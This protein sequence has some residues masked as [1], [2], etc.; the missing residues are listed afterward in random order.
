M[1]LSKLKFV[2]LTSLALGLAG[3]GVAVG[4]A[5]L[6]AR[7]DERT[8]PPSPADPPVAAP[9]EWAG[10]WVANPF[11]DAVAFE[12]RHQGR[13]AR[14]RIYHVK[15]TEAVAEIVRAV[16]V[17]SVQNGT[18]VGLVPPS[19]VLVQRKDGSRFL[20]SVLGEGEL[21]LRQGVIRLSPTFLAAL[22]RRVSEQE[23]KEIDLTQFVPPPPDAA[24]LKPVVQPSRQSLTAGFTELEVVYLVAGH[25]H[26]TRITDPKTIDAL[27][28]ELTI[29]A[30]RPAARERVGA[31]H[32][33]IHS[34]DGSFFHAYLF[35]R[36]EIVNLDV[37]RFTLAPAFLKAISAEVSRRTGRPID[38]TADNPRTDAD[39]KRFEE[40]GKLLAGVKSARITI[41]Y[42]EGD[43]TLTVDDPAEL[44]TLTRGLKLR[45]LPAVRPEAERRT[46]LA[47]LTDADGKKVEITL[48]EGGPAR[49]VGPTL[50][51]LVEISGFGRAWIDNGWRPSLGQ[52]ASLRE[53]TEQAKRND[54]TARLVSANLPAFFREVRNVVVHY[55]EG[56]NELTGSVAGAEC[57]AMLKALSGGR[58]EK[59]DWSQERWQHEIGGLLDRGAAT[60]DL[61]PGLGF[62]L[63]LV[64]RGDKEILVFPYGRLAFANSPMEVLRKAIDAE[65]ADKIELLPKKTP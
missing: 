38:V 59:L 26:R 35:G 3:A 40:F 58:P 33:V 1:S 46:P 13:N 43:R 2:L 16:H 36:D 10:R 41:R 62:S 37:G 23:K 21:Q 12:V 29:R 52:L 60:L 22:A 27:H 11:A 44:A 15:D 56:E 19:Y 50:S 8:A 4:V 9:A 64:V 7:P 34:K 14:D 30:E 54:E 25:A 28:K 48:L 63:P 61:T 45:D 53:Q 57:R 31:A 6:P 24:P 49:D 17:E 65:A 20:A 39:R 47:E 51:D 5:A 32:L 42:P 18:A 55:R